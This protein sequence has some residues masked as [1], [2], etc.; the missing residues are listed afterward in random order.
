M[1]ED[2]SPLVIVDALITGLSDYAHGNPAGFRVLVGIIRGG[3]HDRVTHYLRMT[4]PGEAPRFENAVG[5]AYAAMEDLHSSEQLGDF[6]KD[7]PIA[8]RRRTRAKEYALQAF[9]YLVPLAECLRTDKPKP[10]KRR[11]KP[12]PRQTPL[13]TMQLEAFE[14]VAQHKG[15]RTAAANA[16]GKT[17]Q[18]LDRQYKKALEKLAKG[19][20]TKPKMQSLSEDSRGQVA[21]PRTDRRRKM[22]ARKDD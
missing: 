14:L 10:S 22:K 2:S 8:I 21:I 13:T 6:A 5:D 19:G 7:D 20:I 9:D 11:R 15:N 1:S 3:L 4:R 12:G 18:V 17:R 16:A